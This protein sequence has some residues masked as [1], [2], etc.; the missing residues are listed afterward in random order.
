[1]KKMHKNELEI[2]EV[3]VRRLLAKQCAQ[4]A[5]LALVR[6]LSS[7]TDHALFRLGDSYII[8]LPRIHWAVSGIDKEY[9]WLSRLAANLSIAI[10]V[11]IFKG[12]PDEGYP[13]PWVIS[14][15]HQG[16]P[17]EFE[18][19]NEYHNLA[20]ELA[21]FLNQLHLIPIVENAPKSRRGVSLSHL[22][23]DTKE[24]IN[25]LGQT[26]NIKKLMHLWEEFCQLPTWGK[27]PLWVHGDF[28]PG[29]IIIENQ[30]LSAV[31]DFSDVGIGD[32][33]CDLVIA[34]SLLNL[35][36][37]NTFRESL[38][39]IDDFTWQRGKG[40]ALSIAAIMYPYYK[41]TNPVLA[42][43]SYRI[44]NEISTALG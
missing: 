11:P 36:S 13:W 10:S 43:L 5:D 3:L 17:P 7:G 4:W 14:Y 39:D 2:D 37:R 16:H 42:S 29:N 24:G 26:F 21:V 15:Y 38:N 44:L 20:V 32:P 6:I 33:A 25:N 40:W 12:M 31:I 9:K 8:R 27:E 18:K 30:S 1:M 22:Y 28:L 41:N 34:W 19:T 35:E 23:T